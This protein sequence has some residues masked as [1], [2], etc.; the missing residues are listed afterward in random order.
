MLNLIAEIAENTHVSTTEGGQST[1]SIREIVKN[2]MRAKKQAKQIGEV[3]IHYLT[4]IALESAREKMFL[5]IY[6]NQ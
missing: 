4:S 3:E 6:E 5:Q 1:I 2:L